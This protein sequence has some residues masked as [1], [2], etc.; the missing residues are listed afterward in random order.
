[1]RNTKFYAL[2]VFMLFALFSIQSEAQ[3]V[4]E[5]NSRNSSLIIKGTSSLHDWEMKATKFHTSTTVEVTDEK[6]TEILKV[7]F[8]TP[9]EELT[10]DKWIMDRNAHDALKE[11]THPIIKFSLQPDNDIEVA[12]KDVSISGL[13]TI[14]GKTNVV[15]LSCSYEIVSPRQL[16]VTGKTPLKMSDFGIDP[17]TAMMGTLKTDDEITVQFELEFILESGSSAQVLP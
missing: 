4:F 15:S 6:V 8:T 13:L 5:L 14:A 1:M 3:K 17:P 2:I 11:D 16:K 9:V 7:N 12:V 10:S